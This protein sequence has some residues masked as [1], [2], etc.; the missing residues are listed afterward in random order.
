MHYEIIVSNGHYPLT[1]K[2]ST[3]SEAYGCMEALRTGLLFDGAIDLD[4]VMETLVKMKN[5][6]RLST[7]NY[8]YS[9]S[10]VEGEV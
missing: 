3:M 2:C 7:K 6:E 1:Y 9:I 10:V 8:R 5:G 4:E